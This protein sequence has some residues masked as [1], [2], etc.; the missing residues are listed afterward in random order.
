ML[1]EMKGSWKEN[2]IKTQNNMPEEKKNMPTVD[3]QY[4]RLID[5]RNFHYDNLNKWLMTFYVIIGALLVAFY[6][7]YP[8]N[9]AM[10]IAILGY[11]I[12][13]GAFLSIKGYFYWEVNWIMLIHHFEKVHF[14]SRDERI[15]S[16]FANKETNNSLNPIK[17]ANVS[18]TKVA[19][20]MTTLIILVWG[21]IVVF[22]GINYLPNF[23]IEIPEKSIN[24]ILSIIGSCI[25]TIVLLPLGCLTLQSNL[26]NL[27]DMELTKENIAEPQKAQKK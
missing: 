25:M 2:N 13:I 17:G 7:L 20:V 15:Y 26:D 9:I 6:N 16:I 19:L 1:A 4:Q 22:M 8:H 5:A 21:M 12:S 27:D 18:T 24:I 14:K 3:Q 11:I 23:N 10:L